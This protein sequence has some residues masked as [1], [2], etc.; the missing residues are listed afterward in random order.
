MSWRWAS[1]PNLHHLSRTHRDGPIF[2][3][4]LR[5]LDIPQA[6]A[7]AADRAQVRIYETR[8]GEW[9]YP[10]QVARALKWNK[11]QLA[12]RVLKAGAAD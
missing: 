12:I 1:K 4:V 10:Q 6:V 9:Q 11:N 2:L 7:M 5:I 8:D 3:N